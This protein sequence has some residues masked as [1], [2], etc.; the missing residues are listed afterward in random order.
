MVTPDD[1]KLLLEPALKKPESGRLAA[2]RRCLRTG[3]PSPP[4]HPSAAPSQDI[5]CITQIYI[6]CIYMTHSQMLGKV[7]YGLPAKI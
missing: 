6:M 3:S 4:D 5:L 1:R 7:E 2:L